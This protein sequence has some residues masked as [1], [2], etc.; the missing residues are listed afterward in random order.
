[1]KITVPVNEES[2]EG[3]VGQSFA[4]SPYFLIFDT[5]TNERLFMKNDAAGS[6]GGA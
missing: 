5:D 6:Q 2:I 4:R 1:M 3:N